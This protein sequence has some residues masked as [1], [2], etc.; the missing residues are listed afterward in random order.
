MKKKL[1]LKDCY[2]LKKYYLESSPQ[3]MSKLTGETH[4]LNMMLTDY[5]MD[6]N[7][8]SLLENMKINDAMDMIISRLDKP[9]KL[10]EILK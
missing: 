3:D 5:V 2:K 8:Y 10:K 6:N 1:T 9:N 7:L 4:K